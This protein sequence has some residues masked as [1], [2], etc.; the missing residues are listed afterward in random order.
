LGD[1][2]RIVEDGL[3]GRTLG[4]YSMEGNPLNGSEHIFT[5]LRAY[6]GPDILVLYLG[7]NDIFSGSI[8]GVSSIVFEL[9]EVIEKI[10]RLYASLRIILL[11]PLPVNLGT[12]YASGYGSENDRSIGLSAEFK[13]V[14]VRYGSLFVETSKVITASPIDGVHIDSENH[15][16]LGKHVCALIKTLL[17]E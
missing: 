14:A 11:A 12:V 9:E 5:L 15:I 2:C 7:I 6:G 17:L 1:G 8:E 4:S 16:N 10:N 13:Q 3:N